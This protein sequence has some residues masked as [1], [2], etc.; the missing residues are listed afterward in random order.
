M[1]KF[2]AGAA[3]LLA[4]PL[5]ILGACS[6]NDNNGSV[7]RTRQN[8]VRMNAIEAEARDRHQLDLRA[9]PEENAQ[10]IRSM[11]PPEARRA[12]ALLRE[13]VTLGEDT[14]RVLQRPDLQVAPNERLATR[15]QNARANG[16]AIE[17]HLRR[18]GV[19]FDGEDRQPHRFG[20]DA[21][22]VTAPD[23]ARGSGSDDRIEPPRSDG[24]RDDDLR[25]APARPPRPQKRPAR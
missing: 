5:F 11:S 14:L 21:P 23:S 1:T 25:P 12:R 6:R 10:A 9:S 19:D 18:L 15:L 3:F 24:Y 13:Y 22:I 2:L 16:L 7:D 4:A 8:F 17:N 20:S